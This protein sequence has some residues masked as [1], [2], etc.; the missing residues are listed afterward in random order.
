VEPRKEEEE[1]DLREKC[2]SYLIHIHSEVAK[3]TNVSWQGIELYFPTLDTTCLSLNLY[4]R[5][6]LDTCFPSDISVSIVKLK[7][8]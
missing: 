1:E 7:E 3:H 5:R 4:T 6:T 2:E 8:I